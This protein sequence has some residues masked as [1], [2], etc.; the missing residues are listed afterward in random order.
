MSACKENGR[1][2]QSI[3]GSP[4]EV[5][6]VIEKKNWKS[7]AGE[8]LFNL[9][10]KDMP[11]LPQK[12]P[13]FNVS[14][15][16]PK[17]FSN[18]YKPT[19]NI[20]FVEI[21][22]T[23]YTKG[24]VKLSKDKW[25]SPQSLVKIVAPDD[26]TFIKLLKNNGQQILDY[27]VE[28]EL[29]RMK[30]HLGDHTNSNF[31][32]MIQQQ[33]GVSM[34]VP[35]FIVQYKQEK[36]A[37]WLSTGV[38]EV[39]QDIF[40][41]SY[42]YKDKAMLTKEALLQKRDS[43]NKTFIPGPQKGSYLGTEYKYDDPIFNEIWVDDKYCAEIR[44]LWKVINGGSMGGPFMSHTRIDELHQR[45]IT[46]EVFVYAPQKKKRNSIRQLESLLYSAKLPTVLDEVVIT[47]EKKK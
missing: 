13:F 17:E 11:S 47:A 4:Y 14:H 42:P 37:L 39:R 44:G 40:I 29:D 5:L 31:M 33:F 19:R 16:S 25:S 32:H 34:T 30:D 6:V 15:C 9:L 8:A 3:T 36:D 45:V 21:D 43:I 18:L 38:A 46:I 24:K 23:Q 26:T 20:V 2:L 22:N 12:E 1:F 10:E 35:H 28:G 27:L 41:Y 7:E